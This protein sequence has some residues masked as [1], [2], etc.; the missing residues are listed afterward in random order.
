MPGWVRS[1]SLGRAVSTE[2]ENQGLEIDEPAPMPA[3]LRT[4]TIQRG[5]TSRNVR[6]K[7]CALA[8]KNQPVSQK[9]SEARRLHP[10]A[11]T[12]SITRCR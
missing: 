7:H 9:R 4:A 2:G 10:A 5:W 8:A 11:G 12:G 6:E 3:R 1:V